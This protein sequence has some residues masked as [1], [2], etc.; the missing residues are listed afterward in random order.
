VLARTAAEP[1]GQKDGEK[2]DFRLRKVVEMDHELQE[3][4]GFA[5]T[6]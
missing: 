3:V 2:M 1:I 5:S 4:S 6:S